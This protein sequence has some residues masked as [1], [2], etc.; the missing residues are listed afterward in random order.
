MHG[1]DEHTSDLNV[2]VIK[3]SKSESCISHLFIMCIHTC[4]KSLH[5]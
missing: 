2:V 1:N 5:L 3:T 4:M